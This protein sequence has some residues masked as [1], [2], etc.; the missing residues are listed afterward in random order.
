MDEKQVSQ[1][2]A[3]H[4]GKFPDWAI[5]QLPEILSQ[6]DVTTASVCLC[7]AKDPTITLLLSIF[8][9]HLGIDRLYI[10]DTT[11]GILKLLTCGGCGIWTIID[12]FLIMGATKERNYTMLTC[13]R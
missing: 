10:G 1:L 9:G 2:I 12:W 5:T 13:G 3:I 4:G 6:M 7:Q 8:L 11:L